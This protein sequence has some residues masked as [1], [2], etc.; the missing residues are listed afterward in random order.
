M[1]EAIEVQLAVIRAEQAWLK[2]Q[3]ALRGLARSL[4][5]ADRAAEK[6]KALARLAAIEEA[7][8]RR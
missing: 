5:A 6:A 4:R 8:G 7:Q 3:R 2:Y 1:E